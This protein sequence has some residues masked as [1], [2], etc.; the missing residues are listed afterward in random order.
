M[1]STVPS[2]KRGLFRGIR[3]VTGAVLLVAVLWYLAVL[4]PT[5]GKPPGAGTLFTKPSPVISKLQSELPASALVR[6]PLSTAT[7]KNACEPAFLLK[8]LQGP[9]DHVV[10]EVVKGFRLDARNISCSTYAYIGPWRA[11]E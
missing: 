10:L 9:A 8:P 11:A 7:I 4:F 6:V 1:C 5:L 3:L 2:V